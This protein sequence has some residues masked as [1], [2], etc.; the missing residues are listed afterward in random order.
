MSSGVFAILGQKDTST[1]DIVRSFT[2]VFHMPFLTPSPAPPTPFPLPH[3]PASYELHLRPDKTAAIVDMI[4][5]FG[6]RHVHYLYD[7]DEGLQR[8]QQMFRALG[9][10][11]DIR[12][13]VNRFSDL[14]NIHEELRAVD[15]VVSTL[16]F[17]SIVLDLS[18]G[19]AYRQVLR[20]KKGRHVVSSHVDLIIKEARANITQINLAT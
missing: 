17:K 7:S 20:Q 16:P 1:S 15:A 4:R 2:S 12:F 3:S 14:T 5:H 11:T 19:A 8:L 18:S 10:D 9:N 6:W 13:F